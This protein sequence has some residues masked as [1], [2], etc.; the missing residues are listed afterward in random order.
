MNKK[1]FTLIELLVVVA[2]IGILAAVGLTAFNGFIQGAKQNTCSSQHNTLRKFMFAEILK[3]E[4]GSSHIFVDNN[5]GVGKQCPIT[6]NT[7][8]D[9]FYIANALHADMENISGNAYPSQASA[10]L[11]Y[12]VSAFYNANL[13]QVRNCYKRSVGCH[14]VNIYSN[15]PDVYTLQTRCEDGGNLITSVIPFK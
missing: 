2:I 3:C 7:F 10:P 8:S 9:V 5:T 13:T 14:M 11:T 6:Y 4:L 12:P 15:T 1:G